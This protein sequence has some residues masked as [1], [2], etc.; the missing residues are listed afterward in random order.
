V[1]ACLP[2]NAEIYQVV[3]IERRIERQGV[4]SAEPFGVLGLPP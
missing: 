2:L 4:F 1:T 3:E